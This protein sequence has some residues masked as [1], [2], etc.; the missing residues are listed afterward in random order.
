[1]PRADAF[2]FSKTSAKFRFRRPSI[3]PLR[4]AKL[5]DLKLANILNGETC[6]PISFKDFTTF[7]TEKE[8]TSENLL[9]VIWYKSYEAR[10]NALGQA[11]KEGIP[12]P[13]TSLGDRYDPFKHAVPSLAV[14]PTGSGVS[15][16]AQ[17]MR[18]EASRAYATFLS[19][20]G[21]R[22]LG[23]SDELRMFAQKTL[24]RSTAPQCVR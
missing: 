2:E 18:E 19:P 15:A 20:Q 1:M 7:V 13:S 17:A 24:A 5:D 16:N 4:G 14:P 12:I 21:S 23:V 22:A 10:W 9:F 8:L 6:S 11:E 3:L